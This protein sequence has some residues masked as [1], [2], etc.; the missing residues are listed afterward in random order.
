MK[1]TKKS[2]EPF[3]K[4]IK[5]AKASGMRYFAK[6][7]GS[8]AMRFSVSIGDAIAK[9]KKNARRLARS[10]GCPANPPSVQFG[11]IS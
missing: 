4:E 5:R 7:I 10:A 8:P 1:L 9:A 11:E 2:A 6:A 3:A